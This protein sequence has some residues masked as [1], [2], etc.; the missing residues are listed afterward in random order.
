MPEADLRVFVYGTLRRGCGS[1]AHRRYL[2]NAELIGEG[3]VKGQLYQVDIYP[4]L[5]LDSEDHWV[6]G[7]VYQL[8]NKAT[9]AAL[10]DYEGV[11]LP[12]E[13]PQEYRREVVEVALEGGERIKAWTY[14]Y[15]WPVRNLAPIATGDFLNS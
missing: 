12:F 7:E 4:G 8:P 14:V 10:D 15:N 5:V 2:G 13:N 3:K 1:G 9:L 11:G 6:L